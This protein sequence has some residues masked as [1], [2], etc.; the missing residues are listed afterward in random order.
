[1]SVHLTQKGKGILEQ[2]GLEKV[3]GQESVFPIPYRQGALSFPFSSHCE[4]LIFLS[5]Q[6]VGREK[7]EYLEPS[8]P[9]FVMVM[10]PPSCLL[11]SLAGMEDESDEGVAR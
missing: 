6:G 5:L 11:E 8:L 10:D 9:P 7:R 4:R 2:R 3:V 1:M